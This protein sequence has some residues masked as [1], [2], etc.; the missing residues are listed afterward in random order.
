MQAELDS[1]RFRSNPLCTPVLNPCRPSCPIISVDGLFS[2]LDSMF[3]P[4]A[5]LYAPPAAIMMMTIM[6]MHHARLDRRSTVLRLY[7]PDLSRKKSLN[8]QSGLRCYKVL[9]FSQIRQMARGGF[10]FIYEHVMVCEGYDYLGSGVPRQAGS[11]SRS[12]GILFY[13]TFFF[14]F[15]IALF[16]FS[17]CFWMGFLS[18]SLV[19][20]L[21]NI[22]GRYLY[23]PEN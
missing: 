20:I 7:P 12:F 14:F 17:Y 8:K 15:F 6:H 1:I 19:T 10:L 21:F 23:K 18:L 3:C 2:L 11:A 9:I 5:T 16:F 4:I 13:F 22:P